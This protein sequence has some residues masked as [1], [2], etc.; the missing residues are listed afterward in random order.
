MYLDE[1]FVQHAVYSD[2]EYTGLRALVDP[3]GVFRSFS[4]Y[5]HIE[6]RLAATVFTWIGLASLPI[7]IWSFATLTWASCSA[8]IAWAVAGSTGRQ[9]AGLA[10]GLL[11]ALAPSSNIILLGQLNALQWPMLA[12]GTV[13]AVSGT[14]PRTRAG[15]VVLGA[16]LV[17]LV[18]SAALSFIVLAIL[19]IRSLRGKSAASERRLVAVPSLAFSAQ[20]IAFLRQDAREVEGHPLHALLNEVLYAFH[21]FVPS[22][23]RWP[24]GGSN[25]TAHWLLASS[26]WLV[27]V[28]AFATTIREWGHPLRRR[29]GSYVATAA[30]FLGISVAMNGNLNHQYLVVPTVCLIVAAVEAVSCSRSVM[31][32]TAF[33]VAFA[34]A[35][36]G[37]LPR[38]LNDTFYT[39]PFI[40]D[41][42][43]ALNRAR[44]SCMRIDEVVTIPGT[45]RPLHVPCSRL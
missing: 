23:I 13:L 43:S 1:V 45:S 29:V 19:A 33:T 6:A 27:V 26:W 28:L 18:L 7:L 5:L 44:K 22:P 37:L 42:H 17:V 16:F 40:G 35:S 9:S 8:V 20:A 10:T 41:W 39:Q 2:V 14:R 32:L 38:T 24:Y 4:G 25:T 12:A 31:A 11:F 21:T 15:R 34:I 36:V 30:V 3:L